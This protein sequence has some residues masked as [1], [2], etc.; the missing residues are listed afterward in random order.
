MNFMDKI[1]FLDALVKLYGFAGI[2]DYDTKIC[3]AQYK[4]PEQLI[5]QV[6]SHMSDIRTLFNNSQLQLSRKDYQID[7]VLAAGQSTEKYA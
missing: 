1:K 4:N 2:D 5:T 7:S 3:V 6:N